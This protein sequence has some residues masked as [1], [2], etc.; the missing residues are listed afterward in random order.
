[1]LDCL[2]VGAGPAGAVAALL[3]AR[4]GAR[5]RL[6]DRASFP[7]DKLCGDTINPGTLA[8]LARLGV[9]ASI[10]AR[11]LPVA[12]M[13]IT[14][15]RGVV[16]EARYPPPLCGRA[17]V[18]RELDW[19]LVQHAVAAGCE[20]EPGVTVRGAVV[21]CARKPAVVG[22]R[23]AAGELRARVTIAADGRRSTLAFDLGLTRHPP[24]P[25]RWAIG[26]YVESPHGGTG[27]T[28]EMHIRAG[29]YIGIAPVP[30]GM[31]NICLVKP[32][33]PGDADFRDPA[34]LLRLEIA[35]DPLLRDRFGALRFVA[36][37]VVLG[38]LAVDDARDGIDGL[39]LAGDAAGFVDPMTGDGLR[40][41]VQGG[42]LAARA[43]LDALEHGWSGVHACL[44]ARRRR[45]FAGKHRFNRALRTLVGS[46][47]AVGAAT[48]AAR[49]IPFAVRALVARA[50]DCDLATQY[51]RHEKAD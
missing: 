30:G 34:A 39:V 36:P 50:G 12:G 26:A 17:I 48:A 32:S 21:D 38:P 33:R 6:V 11:S 20:F 7:R 45:A 19:R 37:P 16:I 25:R 13:R 51:A 9:A 23:L 24:R 41:A 29:R 4:A 3:L 18:R 10:D 44:A 22:V 49:V 14:G 43:A 42:E 28:G 2:I 47:R 46:P 5:V 1:M 35:A 8:L 27:V 15:A 40:F 31:T